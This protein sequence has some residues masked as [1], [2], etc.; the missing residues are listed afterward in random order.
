MGILYFFHHMSFIS[1]L[2]SGEQLCELR[3]EKSWASSHPQAQPRTTKTTSVSVGC[4][5]GHHAGHQAVTGWTQL[6]ARPALSVL[7]LV[8][9][10]LHV[11][12]MEWEWGETCCVKIVFTWP[13]LHDSCPYPEESQQD[14]VNIV[15]SNQFKAILKQYVFR[16]VHQS[17]ILPLSF[18]SCQTPPSTYVKQIPK[19]S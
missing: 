15:N 8:Q 4:S 3:C 10:L 6:T 12:T 5:P 17:E 1:L 11:S 19:C 18:Q 9:Q 7:M 13:L 16:E 14:H 2:P